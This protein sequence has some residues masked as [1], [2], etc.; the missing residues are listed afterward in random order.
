MKYFIIAGE[1]SG[2]LHASNL[3]KQLRILDENA[4]FAGWGGD[5]SIDA[6]VD[7]KKHIKD[8]AFMGFVEVLQNLFTI[9]KNFKE[10]KAEIKSYNPDV[11]IFVDYPGFNLRMAEWA[12]KNNF[13]T[14]YLISPNVWAW[15]TSRV[16]K[17][18]DYVDKMYVILPFEK[19]FYKKYDI[20]VEYFGNPLVDLVNNYSPK[21]FDTFCRENNL[22]GKPVVALMAGS[23]KQEIKKMLPLMLKSSTY[24]PDYEFIIT[25]APAIEKRFYDEYLKGYD[26]KLIFNQTYEILSHSVAGLITSGTATL[27]AALFKVPQVVCYKGN[28]ISVIIA[29][30]I[31]HIKHISLVNI[32]LD[33]ECVKELI[34][35]KLTVKNIKEEL[36]KVIPEGVNYKKIMDDYNNL[37]NILNNPDIYLSIAD[38]IL[39]L[40]RS[41]KDSIK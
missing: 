25:G 12:K 18:K 1:A 21:T 39:R 35:N 31:L 2:D 17:I 24:F 38:S 33:K 3:V 9:Q 37:Y 7:V 5:L 41:E 15:K 30:L 14:I 4:V 29:G 34:Q 8:L 36:E 10:C 23:R 19:D 40:I 16:Y 20:E 6:G 26:V 11:I 32:I 28:I 22:S 27:E 13:R